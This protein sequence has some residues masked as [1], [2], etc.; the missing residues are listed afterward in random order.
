[1][2]LAPPTPTA[3]A[4]LMR[5]L[6]TELVELQPQEA[7]AVR[8]VVTRDELPAF[9]ERAF[10]TVAAA[11]HAAGA[12]IAGPPFGYYPEL[13][14]DVVR[15]EAGFVVSD[16]VEAVGNAHPLLL[17][18]GRAVRAMHIGPYDTLERTYGELRRWMSERGL[19]PAD[20]MWEC[21]LSDPVTEPDP[22]D[23]RTLV[24]WPVR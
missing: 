6:S 17:P 15:V 13:P 9:L 11:V 7:V 24:V 5:T 23:W 8:G 14:T 3:H 1:M 4:R 16:H 20:A 2:A 12:E 22:A 19:S 10:G 18:G 21:Y